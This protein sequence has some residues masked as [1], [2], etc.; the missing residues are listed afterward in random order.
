MSDDTGHDLDWFEDY[1]DGDDLGEECEYCG[2]YLSWGGTRTPSGAIA[3]HDCEV[4]VWGTEGGRRADK[5]CPNCERATATLSDRGLCLTCDDEQRDDE[6][7]V[8][9][10]TDYAAAP[11]PSAGES[12]DA[13][14]RASADGPGDASR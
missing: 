1:D 13:A 10:K 6:D 12:P 11:R 3:C 14:G 9:R 8:A 4:D 2:R 5:R 7:R